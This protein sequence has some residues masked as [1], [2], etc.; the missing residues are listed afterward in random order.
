MPLIPH[1]APSPSENLEQEALATDSEAWLA[2]SCVG[3][4]FSIAVLSLVGSTVGECV[5]KL[6]TN[7]CLHTVTNAVLTQ[8]APR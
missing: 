7:Q 2:I 3:T 1:S 6:G 8:F 5:V 4:L